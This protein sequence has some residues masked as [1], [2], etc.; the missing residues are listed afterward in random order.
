MDPPE[1]SFRSGRGGGS[2]DSCVE[3]SLELSPAELCER[4]H[5]SDPKAEA[6]LVE[7]LQPGLRLILHRATGGDLDLA[8]ELCQETLIIVIKRLRT[9]TLREPSELAAFAAQTARN[10]AIAHRRKDAR[11]RTQAD[12]DSV[13]MAFDLGRSQPEEV[14]V[15]R[16]GAIVQRLLDQLPTER[17]RSILKRFYLHEEDKDTICHDLSLSDLA[18]NQ[19]LFRAR[20]RFRE[21]ITSA[22]L[23]KDD[24]FESELHHE[25]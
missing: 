7:R 3:S 2:E 16:L 15:G 24:L 11:R 5:A 13:N 8:H 21:L 19:V 10:L 17:D 4:I 6:L 14:A 18:F 22:G 1:S 23:K 25:Q 12:L 9:S 20:N